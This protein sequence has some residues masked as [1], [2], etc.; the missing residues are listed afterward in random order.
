MLN[1][2]QSFGLVDGV[3][4][5]SLGFQFCADGLEPHLRRVLHLRSR[6]KGMQGTD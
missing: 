2:S 6:R 4:P 1:A 3:H 5:N